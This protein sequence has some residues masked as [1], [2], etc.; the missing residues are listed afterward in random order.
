MKVIARISLLILSVYLLAAPGFSQNQEQPLV[1]G[2]TICKSEKVPAGYKIVGE[3]N[4]ARC[5]EG[6]WLIR[7]RD[8]QA[9]VTTEARKAAPKVAIQRV[10]TRTNDEDEEAVRNARASIVQAKRPG[11]SN[12]EA[13]DA[14]RRRTVL[15]GMT[16]RDAVRAWG[17][18]IRVNTDIMEGRTTR[19]WVYRRG[20]LYFTN[21]IL[22]YVQFR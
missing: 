22:D 20:Y 17:R 7:T 21:G 18:P 11:L 6:A 19:Q 15:F 4:D 1:T 8:A 3:T 10:A 2:K 14:I 13:E 5:P 12:R 9:I 16:E